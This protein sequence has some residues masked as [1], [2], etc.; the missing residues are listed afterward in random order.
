MRG[1]GGGPVAIV[2]RSF[3]RHR[4]AG[5]IVLALCVSGCATSSPVQS[6]VPDVRGITIAFESIEGP[7]AAVTQRFARSLNEETGARQIVVVPAGR[8]AQYRVRSY[9]ATQATTI[10]WAWDI[11]DAAQQ[12]AF[13]LRGEERAGGSS[14]AAANDTVLRR[15][16]RAGVEQF[17]AFLATDRAPASQPAAPRPTLGGWSIAVR[18]DL[19]P[20][21]AGRGLPRPGEAATLAYGSQ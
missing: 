19:N 1:W 20:A 10:F 13:R 7:P 21:S 18:D 12:R 3:S 9:L 6:T 2:G 5:V 14:W 17:G 16:A 4:I 15:V 11:Y 8:Q